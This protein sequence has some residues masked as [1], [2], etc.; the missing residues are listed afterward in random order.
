MSPVTAV[1]TAVSTVMFPD[2]A[3]VSSWPAVAAYALGLLALLVGQWRQHRVTKNV[4]HQVTNDGGET[5]KD[6]V[7]RTE[8]GQDDLRKMLAEH[9]DAE[10]TRRW[11]AR[12]DAASF[13]AIAA[14]LSVAVTL[15]RTRR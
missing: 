12:R 7:D 15:A 11:R 10:P 1:D 3:A 14:L 5:L 8:Q 2:V 9:I 6:A 4:Q 13:A